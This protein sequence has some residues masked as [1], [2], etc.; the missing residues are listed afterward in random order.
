VPFWR[1]GVDTGGTFSDLAALSDDGATLAILKV[2]S[3]PDDP[4]R[5]LADGIRV[6]LDD[7]GVA[8]TAVRY[9]GHGTTVCLN[10]ILEEKGART[11]L[12]TTRGM[13]DL[14]ALRRQTRDHLYDLHAPAPVP[15]VPRRLRLE[16]PERVLFEGS[17]LEPLDPDAAAD[18]IETLRRG[19][20]EALAV[21]LLHAYA[22]PAHEA[23]V[24][25]LAERLAPRVYVSVS[26]EVLPEFREYERLST[27]VLNAYVGPLMS[28]YLARLEERVASLGLGVPPHVLLSNGGVATIAH[29]RA[30]PVFT[31]ASG[32]SGGVTGAVFVAREAG[33]DHVLTFDMGGTST[34]VCLVEHGVPATASEKRYH[35]H[36]VKGAML[37][38]HSIGAGGGSVAWVDAGGFLRV[39]PESAGADPGPACYG[40]GGARPTVTDANLVLGRLGAAGLLGGSLRLDPGLAEDAIGTALCGPLG[41]DVGRAAARVVAVVDAAMA[42]ALRLAAVARG[43]DPR[44]FTLVAFGGAG[45]MHATAVARQVG[46]RRVLVP[47]RPGV[48][49]ALGLVV[50]DLRTEFSRTQIAGIDR[51][52]PS[53]LEALYRALERDARAWAAASGFGHAELILTRSADLRHTRQNHELAVTV[54]TRVSARTLAGVVRAFHRAHRRAYGYA[55]PDAPTELVTARVAA[56]IPVAPPNLVA[57]AGTSATV[58]GARIGERRV[59]F[60]ETGFAPCPIYDR[61]RLP[62]GA[63]LA[64]PAILE[65]LDCT[66]V[67]GPRDT[68]EVDGRGNLVIEVPPAG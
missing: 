23:V 53:E 38:V 2:P 16:V 9:L 51:L 34:D 42:A 33:I 44:T 40:R 22:N 50:A 54:P 66:T 25:A 26:S 63:K 46:I 36:P 19:D 62:T 4:S 28:R 61:T 8:P 45:P 27:T 41:H 3:T 49:C 29:A 20:V 35:G 65:Q 21:C 13:R 52:D 39:G 64:G 56:R 60:A 10:A 17:V 47:S 30:R 31:M 18:A 11:G 48:L 57:S 7:N 5:A 24:R 14:L 55:T 15:L 67:V 58:D 59:C 6:L 68:V 43:A 37:D 32:P 12:I 1:L